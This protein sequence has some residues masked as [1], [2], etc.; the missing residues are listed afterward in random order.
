MY[1]SGC[2]YIENCIFIVF[3]KK[4]EKVLTKKVTLLTLISKGIIYHKML[5]KNS[6]TQALVDQLKFSQRQI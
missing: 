4:N 2:M 5:N 6:K 3:L 1:T